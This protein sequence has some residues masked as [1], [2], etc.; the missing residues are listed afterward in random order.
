MKNKIKEN[1]VENTL[2]NS[3]ELIARF[4]SLNADMRLS[5]LLKTAK[6]IEFSWG[7]STLRKQQLEIFQLMLKS[8]DTV[9]SNEQQKLSVLSNQITQGISYKHFLGILLPIERQFGRSAVDHEFIITKKDSS[10]NAPIGPKIPIVCVL[11]NLRSS[12]NVGSIFRT[13]E[14][15][16]FEK[17]FLCGYTATPDDKKTKKTTMQTEQNIEWAWHSS[18][19]QIIEDLKKQNFFILG[20]ET[21]TFGREIDSFSLPESHNKLALVLGNEKFGLEES[22]LK[23]CHDVR[24]IKLFGHKN[25]LNVGVAFGIAAHTFS[26]KMRLNATQLDHNS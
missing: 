25:S 20:L 16:S 24:Q 21:T 10:A 11:D 3:E 8:L 26:S 15:F 22:T 19:S 17:L 7:D 14:C 13:A 6:A 4:I 5:H 1:G 9:K 18:T 12:F 23:L 2:D